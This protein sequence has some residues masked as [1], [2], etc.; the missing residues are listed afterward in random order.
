[1]TKARFL[2]V[3]AAGLAL[4][5]LL[6]GCV[7]LPNSVI[8]SD[9]GAA[10]SKAVPEAHG[11]LVGVSYDGS[12]A[13]RAIYVKVYIGRGGSPDL[14]SIVNRAL[15]AAWASSPVA[16]VGIGLAVVDGPKPADASTAQVDG[17]DLSAT[18]KKLGFD[19]AWLGLRDLEV[20]DSGMAKIYG[21]WP[22][23]K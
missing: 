13:R 5:A 8:T 6:S 23:S 16:P 4:A 17:V 10:V 18:A 11:I 22:G 2:V 21:A 20:P 14:S 12:P 15:K 3:I 7:A 9:V 1:M 19:G